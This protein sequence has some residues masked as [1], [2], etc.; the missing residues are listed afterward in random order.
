M[1]SKQTGVKLGRGMY[2]SVIELLLDGERVAGKIFKWSGPVMSETQRRKL[3]DEI[4]IVLHLKHPKLES[5]KDL[6]VEW[7][8]DVRNPEKKIM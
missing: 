8:S 4:R 5:W 6:Q 2:G 7:T 3:C 1:H